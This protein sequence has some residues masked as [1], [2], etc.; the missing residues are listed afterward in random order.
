MM[1]RG[2]CGEC[3]DWALEWGEGEVWCSEM[4]M[5]EIG[6]QVRNSGERWLVGFVLP[7]PV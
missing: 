6:K 3:F 2:S 7:A 5:E 1:G 4:E